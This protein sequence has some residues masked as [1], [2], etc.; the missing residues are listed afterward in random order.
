MADSPDTTEITPNQN[1]TAQGEQTPA[2]P[3]QTSAA[4]ASNEQNEPGVIDTLL[5]KE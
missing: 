5:S 3:A 2:T 1:Q 4:E